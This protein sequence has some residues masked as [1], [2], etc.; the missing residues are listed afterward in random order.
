MCRTMVSRGCPCFSYMAKR[1]QGS[2]TSI[3]TNAA[4]L[5][6]VLSF[7]RKKSGKPIARATEKHSN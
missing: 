3:I 7:K 2:M 6:P 4:A 1:K 5:V